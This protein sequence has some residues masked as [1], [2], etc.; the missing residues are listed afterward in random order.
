MKYPIKKYIKVRDV[1]VPSFARELSVVA[2]RLVP[3]K[4]V[5]NWVQSRGRGEIMVEVD[6]NNFKQVL[7]VTRETK[8]I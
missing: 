1:T 8:I 3:E 6:P 7:G 4:T 2:D 5:W